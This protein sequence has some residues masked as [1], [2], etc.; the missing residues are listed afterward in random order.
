MTAAQRPAIVPAGLVDRMRAA[1]LIPVIE[2]EDSGRALTLAQ[3]LDAGGLP[4]VEIVFRTDAAAEALR[5]IASDVPA[6]LLIAGTV[7]STH[8]VDVARESGASLVIS[9]GLNLRVVEH[10]ASIGMPMIP[11]TATPTEIEAAMSAGATTVKLFPIEPLGGVKY[12]KAVAAPYPGM[13]WTPTGGITAEALPGYLEIASV[14][15]CGGSWVAPRADVAA[16]NFEAIAARAARAVEIVRLA[17][18]RRERAI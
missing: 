3:A 10:A 9:P 5:R 14:L 2:I 13:T 16:G 12:L 18:A 15:A 17:R 6:I 7:T 4:I 1:G 8:L 11:G